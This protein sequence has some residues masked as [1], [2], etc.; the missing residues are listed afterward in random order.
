MQASV[1]PLK[2]L[3]W[4]RAAVLQIGT[5]GKTKGEDPMSTKTAFFSALCSA[6]L[7]AGC[8]T[9]R[10]EARAEAL[11]APAA[12]AGA[13]AGRGAEPRPWPRRRRRSPRSS[14]SR[15]P[16]CSSST[17]RRSLPTRAPSSTPEVIAKLKDLG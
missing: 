13:D 10:T 8:A 16:S 9:E 4:P 17:R 14:T 7:V 15:R 2:T 3:V 11:A 6:A 12:R 5:L 1:F